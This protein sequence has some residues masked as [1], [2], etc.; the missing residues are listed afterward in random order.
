MKT[1]TR[2]FPEGK[3][4][5]LSECPEVQKLIKKGWSVKKSFYNYHRFSKMNL[6]YVVLEKKKNFWD[7]FKWYIIA[8]VFLASMAFVAAGMGSYFL[9]WLIKIAFGG[10]L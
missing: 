9:Y 6:T 8:V 7:R 2:N 1:I 10:N 5:T 3:Y 4:K